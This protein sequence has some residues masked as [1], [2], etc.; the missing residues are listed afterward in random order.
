MNPDAQENSMYQVSLNQGIPTVID[1]NGNKV[2]GAYAIQIDFPHESADTQHGPIN[3]LSGP[4][5]AVIWVNGE[6]YMGF[7]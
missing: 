6:T 7:L 5:S 4:P 1:D 2:R 3:H